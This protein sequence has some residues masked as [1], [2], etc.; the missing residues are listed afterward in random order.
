VTYGYG[1][2][3]LAAAL[4]KRERKAAA[5]VKACAATE[6]GR[7]Y[8]RSAAVDLCMYAT[9]R[10]GFWDAHCTTWQL[11][12]VGSGVARVSHDGPLTYA[13]A[14][15][16]WQQRILTRRSRGPIGR[17]WGHSRAQMLRRLRSLSR[18][19]S[20]LPRSEMR[21]CLRGER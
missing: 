8:E 19:L 6:E 1:W 10:R 21:A 17:T 15:P 11:T 12:R 4:R 9:A 3:V 18:R 13:G 16:Q 2:G 14:V 7:S 20:K 5:W